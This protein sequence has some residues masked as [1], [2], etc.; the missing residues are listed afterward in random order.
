[1]DFTIL[2]RTY[3]LSSVYGHHTT[4]VPH[5]QTLKTST[6]KIVAHQPN[7]H[8]GK[9]G[10]KVKRKTKRR[11]N[12]ASYQNRQQ[13]NMIVNEGFVVFQL[14]RMLLSVR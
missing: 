8:R 4:H 7:G 11:K 14:S 13:R 9:I 6:D 5:H 10:I 3:A 12:N 2:S 1:M